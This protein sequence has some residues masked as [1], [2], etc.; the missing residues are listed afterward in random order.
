MT[1]PYYSP[2]DNCFELGGSDMVAFFFNGFIT[3]LEMIISLCEIQK[4]RLNFLLN[5]KRGKKLINKDSRL[6]VLQIFYNFWQKQKIICSLIQNVC[7]ISK[8]LDVLGIGFSTEMFANE[9]RNKFRENGNPSQN[10]YVSEMEPLT[11]L[12]STDDLTSNDVESWLETSSKYH[13]CEIV[14]MDWKMI[15]LSH[16][17]SQFSKIN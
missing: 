11:E 5:K 12:P 15:Y 6:Y 17:N 3:S 7:C 4:R 8:W 1:L 16:R 14:D 2:G 13:S 10:C 9:N